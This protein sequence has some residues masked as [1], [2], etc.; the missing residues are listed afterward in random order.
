MPTMDRM[1][2][3]RRK[4]KASRKE[5]SVRLRITT[6]QKEKFTTAAEKVGLD[7]SSWLRTI[8]TREAEK[9]ADG[10]ASAAS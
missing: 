9:L 8:A 4:P 7:L 1:A 6:A 5:E 10:D 3:K 2:L